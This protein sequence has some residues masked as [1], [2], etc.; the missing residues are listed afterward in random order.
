[1]SPPSDSASWQIALHPLSLAKALYRKWLVVGAVWLLGT[2]GVLAWVSRMEAVY[3]AETLILV[4]SQKIPEKFVS[5]TVPSD[6]RDRLATLRQ[7]ILSNARLLSIVQTFNLY[8][9]EQQASGMEEILERMRRDIDIKIEKGWTDNQPGA[10]RVSYE[11]NNP[12]IVAE[13]AN[14]LGNLF[15]DQNLKAREV[16]AE[17]TLEFIRSQLDQAKKILDDQ[18][19]SVSRYKLEHN[20]ELPEQVQAL[21]ATL[22]QLGVRLQ[23]NQD[24]INRAYSNQITLQSG[25]RLAETVASA[26]QRLKKEPD[27]SNQ[28]VDG[29]G[30]PYTAKPEQM[31]RSMEAELASLLKRYTETH[32]RVQLL[33][34]SIERLKALEEREGIAAIVDPERAESARTALLAVDRELESRRKENELLVQEVQSVQARLRKAPI[35]EQEM[36]AL[37]RDYEMSKANYKSLLDKLLAAEMAAEMEKRQKAERFT[38]LDSARVPERPYKPDRIR[39]AGLGSLLMLGLGVL[40]GVGP[41]LKRNRVLGEWELPAGMVVLG[42]IPT[43]SPSA[44]ARPVV[45]ARVHLPKRLVIYSAC[46]F[47]VAIFASVLY[48]VW[49]WN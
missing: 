41:E 48:T 36:A 20:G 8:Q 31:L 9:R 15:V 30:N 2:L 13:V 21:T 49:T 24:A 17:G 4:D 27:T 46:F 32:P 26:S 16:Q 14:R 3:R 18:E 22:T 28:P 38:V 37:T 6:L 43:I 45:R 1:M 10:F 29:S 40:A 7:Q 11:G 19:A 47:T 44:S 42:R 23:G 25:L 12:A 34:A 39:L 5:A 33:R 35:R